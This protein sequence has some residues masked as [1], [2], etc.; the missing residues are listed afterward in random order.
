MEE[1]ENIIDNATASISDTSSPKINNDLIANSEN[2][3]QGS[4]FRISVLTERL[5][6]LEYHP[7]GIFND[8]EST[9]IKFRNIN[10]YNIKKNV[11]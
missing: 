10:S 6:R 5:I 9:L 7:N 3:I 2:V 8:L 1:K 4:C 11:S